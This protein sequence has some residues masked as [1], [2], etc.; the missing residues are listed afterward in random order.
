MI[1]WYRSVEELSL[2]LTPARDASPEIVTLNPKSCSIVRH[3]K[4]IALEI[5]FYDKE[6]D[7]RRKYENDSL[8]MNNC[9]LYIHTFF[10]WAFSVLKKLKIIQETI[11]V[12]VPFVYPSENY[13]NFIFCHIYSL[14]LT[15]ID[16]ALSY[17]L[18]SLHRILERRLFLRYLGVLKSMRNDLK[19]ICSTE[20]PTVQYSLPL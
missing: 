17:S 8:T 14:S 16:N 4:N 10:A 15:I 6:K 2:T 9:F 11:S 3:D 19:V 13:Q 20:P 5:R 7:E 18:L 1:V 12:V